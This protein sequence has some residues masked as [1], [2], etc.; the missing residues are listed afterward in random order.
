MPCRR[1]I[2]VNRITKLEVEIDREQLHRLD[3]QIELVPGMPAE[4]FIAT[5]ERT[6][7]EYLIQPFLLV[8]EHSFR[9]R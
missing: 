1:S 5:T 9:E 2:P 4:A 8:V 7:L 3:P 6:V